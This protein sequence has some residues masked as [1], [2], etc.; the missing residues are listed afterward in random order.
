[1]FSLPTLRDA[2]KRI[3]SQAGRPMSACSVFC[4]VSCPS[5]SQQSK[6]QATN[7]WEI[8]RRVVCGCREW[9][10]RLE[11]EA[12]PRDQLA[13]S[14]GRRPR[15][16]RHQ[17]GVACVPVPCSSQR[18]PAAAGAIT[19]LVGPVIMSAFRA[20]LSP[21]V[22]SAAFAWAFLFLTLTQLSAL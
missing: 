12:R 17:G 16:G 22:S 4:S 21:A 11:L 13:A 10:N 18:Q 1:M 14:R 5:V 3:K 19:S 9:G 2:R 7:M 15:P 6:V 20:C 8:S